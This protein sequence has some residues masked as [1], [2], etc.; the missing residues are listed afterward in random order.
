MVDRDA[1]RRQARVGG[2]K[3]IGGRLGVPSIQPGAR[4]RNHIDG[5]SVGPEERDGP[6]EGTLH[7]ETTLVHRA[8]M[9]AAERQ[10]V[11]EARR[12]S[13]RPMGDVVGVATT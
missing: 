4:W 5:L 2:T 6:I 10:Q 11:V 3:R 7:S 13:V 8:V 1:R 9:P 12:T